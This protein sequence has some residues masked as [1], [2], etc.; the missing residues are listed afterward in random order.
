MLWQSIRVATEASSPVATRVVRRRH[1]WHNVLLAVSLARVSMLMYN[2]HWNL[3]DRSFEDTASTDISLE[4]D[5]RQRRYRCFV[6]ALVL[7]FL[8]FIGSALLW[9]SPTASAHAFVI[10]SDPV[11]GST[12]DAVPGMVRIYFNGPIS[13]AL[14]SAHVFSVQNGN[15]VD[16]SAG[17][18]HVSPNTP[19]E[20][21]VALQ[22]P[23][24]QH[25]GSYEVRWT[26][27]SV[28][29]G[30]TTYGLIG[31]NVGF[32]G[33]GLSGTPTLGPSTSNSLEGSGSVRA[34]SF[35]GG[36]S[37]ARERILLIALTF[38]IG[39]L[40]TE[41]LL[42]VTTDR[43]SALLERARKQAFS[44][45]WLCLIIM[46]VGEVVALLLRT[47]KLSQVQDAIFNPLFLWQLLTDTH[48]GLLWFPRL[49]LL[50]VA[51]GLLYRVKR[52]PASPLNASV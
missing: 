11:D 49:F 18:A 42:L 8:L 44:L 7:S 43:T 40:I 20:L 4:R 48:Y 47:M 28:D 15:L 26:A 34:L 25:Q 10:G 13:N 37:I 24:A 9:Q 23:N 14:S 39:I 50:L 21:D 30:H 45:Q 27:L 35:L 41:R 32:S 22:S 2:F 29:D 6:A 3:L 1:F 52:R 51:L 12:V 36:L 5:M 31:F 38:L 16:I 19:R 17:P 46:L 33:T